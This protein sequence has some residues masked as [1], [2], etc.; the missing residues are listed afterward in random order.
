MWNIHQENKNPHPAPFPVQLA[1]RCISSV[2]DGYVLDPFMGSGTTG[3]AAE[4]LK[5]NW[6]GIEKSEPYIAMAH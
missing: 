5:R 2:D 1:E 4:K 3:I 6:L